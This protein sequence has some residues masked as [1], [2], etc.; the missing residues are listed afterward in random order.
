[1]VSFAAG[2]RKMKEGAIIHVFKHYVFGGLTEQPFK[3]IKQ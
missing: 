3:T 1:M 2:K